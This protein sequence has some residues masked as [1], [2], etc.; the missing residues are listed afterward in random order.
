[1]I[2][3]KKYGR[4]RIDFTDREDAQLIFQLCM[5]GL[6]SKREA[7]RL[8]NTSVMTVSRRIKELQIVYR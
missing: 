1:M 5:D 6:I 3:N 7:A 8:L 2:G 4:K